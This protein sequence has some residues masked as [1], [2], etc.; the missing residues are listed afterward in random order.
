MLSL[1][2]GFVCVLFI[3][4]SE[5]SPK[6]KA[7]PQDG[8]Y[9]NPRP[10]PQYGDW[11]MNPNPA[12]QYG[13]W[14]MN[15]RPAPQYGDWYMNPN[16]GP[17]YGGWYMNGN[18]GKSCT[19]KTGAVYK[20]GESRTCADGCNRCWCSNGLLA[21]TRMRCNRVEGKSCTDGGAV[22]KNGET[23]ACECNTCRCSNGLV[24][25]TMMGCGL[26]DFRS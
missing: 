16:P 25:S 14:Y 3:L 7:A 12:P 23:W 1:K 21:S 8:G 18:R 6:P 2:L 4:G 26:V 20:D 11:Y 19:D 13:D 9:M 17:Q 15:P 10:A 24:L 22:Y 5:A